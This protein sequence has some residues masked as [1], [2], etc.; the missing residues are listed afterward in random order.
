MFQVLGFT[1]HPSGCCTV[2]TM[3]RPPPCGPWG[4]CSTLSSAVMFHSTTTFR[5]SPHV[6]P[7]HGINPGFQQERWDD[8]LF[9]F[10][11]SRLQWPHSKMSG[12]QTSEQNKLGSNPQTPLGPLLNF[13]IK[14]KMLAHWHWKLNCD[15][16]PCIQLSSN[17]YITV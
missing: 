13:T 9:Q 11:V 4:S 16:N 14:H 3:V 5:S 15:Y 17:I 6:S 7:S 1:P 10:C 8:F 2:A 12:A